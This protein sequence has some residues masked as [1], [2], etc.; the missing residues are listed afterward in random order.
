MRHPIVDYTGV[1]VL[2]NKSSVNLGGA[3]LIAFELYFV[4]GC[5][6]DAPSKN[7]TEYCGVGIMLLTVRICLGIFPY[8]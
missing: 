2:E 3:L 4:T 1:Q 6:V 7:G 5:T 8:V